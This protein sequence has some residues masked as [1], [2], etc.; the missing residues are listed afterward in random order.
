MVGCSTLRTMKSPISVLAL[1]LPVALAGQ[2]YPINSDSIDHVLRTSSD[3]RARLHALDAICG[4]WFMSDRALPYLELGDALTRRLMA[5]PD[6]LIRRETINIRANLLYNRGYHAKFHRDLVAAQRDFREA[7]DLGWSIGDTMRVAS[8]LDAIGV[9]YLALHLPHQALAHFQEE[10]ELLHAMK[11]IPYGDVSRAF[12]HGA[13]AL[14]L[15]GRHAE[16]R[17]LLARCDTSY[18][19]YHALTLMTRAQVEEAEGHYAKARSTMEYA[20]RRLPQAHPHWDALTVLEPMAAYLLRTGDARAALGTA[21]ECAEIAAKIGDDAAWCGCKC[22]EGEALLLLN[23]RKNAKLVLQQALDTAA[24]WGYI[25]LSRET[26]DEGS[27][28]HAASLLKDLYKKDGDVRQALDM[29]ERW[30]AWKDTVQRMEARDAIFRHDLQVAQFTDSIADAE[31]TALATRETQSALDTERGRS[32]LMLLVIIIAMVAAAAFGWSF[33]QR[34]RRDR[35]TAHFELQRLQQEHMIRELRMREQMSQ[36]LH[37]DLG[38]GLSALKLW[39][40][41]AAEEENDPRRRDQLVRRSAMADELIAS[42]RQIIWTLNS[43][44]T[45]LDQLVTYLTDY[46]HLYCAQRGLLLHVRENTPWPS[47]HLSTAQRRDTFLI[48]REALLNIATHAKATSVELQMDWNH[49]LRLTVQDDGIGMPHGATATTG[50]GIRSMQRRATS[51]GGT[52]TFDGDRGTRVTLFVPLPNE[53]STGRA[54][55]RTNFAV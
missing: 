11:D 21:H 40:D 30:A 55:D 48:M 2:W 17:S 24:R 38:A 19:S 16:A 15:Q 4:A 12:Q 20:S 22:I 37:E 46:A 31:R 36:D 52:L 13:K 23:D 53:S 44:A 26:G 29:T 1:L 8:C 5:H 27:M 50:N 6:D 39:S 42:L 41:M 14:L 10:A 43:S 25:G 28:I 18:G 49:G 34:R 33:F 47:L 45:R 54:N 3:D 51:L 7:R 32:R 9:T 35:I